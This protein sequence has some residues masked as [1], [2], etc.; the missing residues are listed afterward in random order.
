VSVAKQ[1]GLIGCLFVLV[2]IAIVIVVI[3][4]AT[5]PNETGHSSPRMPT[6]TAQG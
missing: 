3:A 5:G 1:R 2:V 6:N 4:A